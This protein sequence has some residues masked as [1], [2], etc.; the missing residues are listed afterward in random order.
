MFLP[1][2]IYNV[3]ETKHAHTFQML[4]EELNECVE[5]ALN[6]LEI[7]EEHFHPDPIQNLFIN[8]PVPVLDFNQ[9]VVDLCP[10]LKQQLQWSKYKT[11]KRQQIEEL[12]ITLF[13]V[14]QLFQKLKVLFDN[15]KEFYEQVVTIVMKL[16]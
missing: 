7:L 1:S 4:T 2:I 16:M 14:D 13:P 8:I 10:K 15:E 11:M 12:C 6:L 3:L 9:L 5:Q